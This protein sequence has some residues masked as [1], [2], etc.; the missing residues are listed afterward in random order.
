VAGMFRFMP[1]EAANAVMVITPQA[2]YLDDIQQWLERIDGAGAGV[3]L[4]SYELK[5]IKAADLAAR[6]SEAF[7]GHSSTGSTPNGPPSMMPGTNPTEIRD[8]GVDDANNM[9]T[10]TIGGDTGTGG[11]GDL[12]EGSLSLNQAGQGNAAAMLEVGGEKVG[13]SAVDETNTLLVRSSGQAW[14]SIKE[15]IEKLDVMPLQVHI[16]AQIAQVALTGDLN[17][18][19]SW[20]FQNAIGTRVLP[21][22]VG[23]RNITGDAGLTYTF[24]SGNS[25]AFLQ[26]LDSVTDVKML[27]TPSVFVRNNSEA[28]FNVGTNIPIASVSFN[29]TTGN[30]GT[31]SQ[32]QYLQTGTILKVRPRIT[33]D[34]MVFLDLVQEISTPGQVPAICS[35]NA[36]N[37]SNC[38]PPIDTRKLKTEAAVQ[39]GETVL[40]AGLIDDRTTHTSGGFPGLSRIPVIGGLFGHQS[41]GKGRT[42][43]IILITPTIVRDPKEARDL[44]DEYGRRFRAMEPLYRAPK[45]R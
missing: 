45:Q 28:T 24:L 18:G 12:G 8:S 2:D 11:G 19:V 6:L 17:Y 14:R 20:Y 22:G 9:G 44:T 33:K 32:V 39:S 16:E 4:F 38:N 5:Y 25:V 41:S 29:P 31:F 23:V 7:G 30:E 1:L 35:T 27:Q 42:E 21:T 10:A 37:A 13:V 43:T 36:G 26:A 34:G 15:V 3:Q 40:L